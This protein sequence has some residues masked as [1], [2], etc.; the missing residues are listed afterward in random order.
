[1]N[2]T[3]PLSDLE[4]DVATENY[5]EVEDMI[6]VQVKG[7]QRKHRWIHTNEVLSAAGNA[8]VEAV[9]T[10]KAVAGPFRNWVS[11]KVDKAL[12]TLLRETARRARHFR[13]DD[14]SVDEAPE[15]E[16]EARFWLDEWLATLSAD[17]RQV[18]MM[19]FEPPFTI[20][21]R[22]AELGGYET[23]EA[24]RSG[25]REYLRD[26]GWTKERIEAAFQEIK[27]RL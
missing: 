4:K 22:V 9:A 18:A 17:A 27:E 19:V 20:H 8:Y 11:F 21:V 14:G 16:K 25:V 3:N 13:S 12:K 5:A 2:L 23:P 1:M 26:G 24:F 15:R 7:F 10:Y 6:G